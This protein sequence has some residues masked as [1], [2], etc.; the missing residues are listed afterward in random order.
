MISCLFISCSR[1]LSFLKI[2]QTREMQLFAV[3]FPSPEESSSSKSRFSWISGTLLSDIPKIEVT[4]VLAWLFCKWN[5]ECDCFKTLSA[6]KTKMI[7]RSKMLQTYYYYYYLRHVP[8]GTHCLGSSNL[9]FQK[10]F[11][12]LFERHQPLLVYLI[13]PVFL[14]FLLRTPLEKSKSV[15]GL[16]HIL[17]M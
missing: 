10:L 15:V 6:R 2:L 5:C 17:Y 4:S 9:N 12:F 7:G 3:L 16:S 13:L 11:F 14:L 1:S 8:Q